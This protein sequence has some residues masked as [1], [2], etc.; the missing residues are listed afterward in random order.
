MQTDPIGYEDGMNWYAYVGN[1]PVNNTDP[2][3]MYGKGKGWSDKDWKKFD[4]AQKKAASDMSATASSI[5]KE[6]SGLES[7]ATSKD[8]YS[9]SELTSMA[10]DLDAGAAALNDD[11]SNG[12]FANAV[13]VDDIG[14]A[15]ANAVLGGQTVNIATDD[16]S[17]GNN[18]HTRWMAGHEALHNVGLDHPEYMGHI[19]Y[20]HG[21]KHQN[22]SYKNLG[23]HAPHK[24][25]KNPDHVMSQ[26]YR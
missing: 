24:R 14:G 2:S 8:G 9:A 20:R 25:Y 10:N 23:K 19:P 5:R 16:K 3:G 18:Y 12:Y 21:T 4:A 22:R 7:G 26:V 11:G 17:F 13:S 15:R 6:A 1:D